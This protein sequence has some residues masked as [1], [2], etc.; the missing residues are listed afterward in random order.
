MH[1]LVEEKH[2]GTI[3]VNSKI[4]KGTEFMLT[5]ICKLVRATEIIDILNS[6]NTGTAFP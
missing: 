1:Y 6:R 4:G 5:L 2:G 3:K